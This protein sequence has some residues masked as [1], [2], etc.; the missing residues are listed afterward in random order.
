MSK[1]NRELNGLNWQENAD[2]SWVAVTKNY[3]CVAMPKLPEEIP[4]DS[5]LSQYAYDAVVYRWHEVEEVWIQIER[6]L[7]GARGAQDAMLH[8]EQMLGRVLI[9]AEREA[10]PEKRLVDA[11]KQRL[12]EMQFAQYI[13]SQPPNRR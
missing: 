9:K 6:A 12:E 11:L 5:S 8:A 13:Q 2:G 3:K 1:S 7:F 10:D 4:A